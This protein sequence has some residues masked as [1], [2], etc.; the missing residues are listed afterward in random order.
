MDLV[1]NILQAAIAL[2]VLK[3]WLITF[4]RE[5]DYRGG[6]ARTLAE[7]FEVYG[8]PS[9]MLWAV[10]VFKV[11]ASLGL[12]AGLLWPS[13]TQPA[14]VVLAAF[15]LGAV[16]MHIKVR[17]EPKKSLPSTSILLVALFVAFYSA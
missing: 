7:E 8:L 13:V 6:E 2:A 3:V 12:L 4:R 10:G 16:A 9:W 14:A 1:V 17:D 11:A 15:M 5:S